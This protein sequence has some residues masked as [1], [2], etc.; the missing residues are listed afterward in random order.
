M[1]FKIK[2]VRVKIS[3]TFFAMV[4]LAVCLDNSGILL[5]SLISSLFHELVHIIFIFLCG[6]KISELSLSILGG[7]IQRQQNLKLSSIKE[8]I[9]SLSAPVFNIFTGA[10]ML[11]C[12]FK[13]VGYVNLVIGLLNVLPF[14]DFDGGRG[15]YYLLS[16]FLPQEK[17][18]IIQNITSVASVVLISSVTVTLFFQGGFSVSLVILGLYMI[19]SL[20]KNLSAE[21][22]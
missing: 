10:F 2:S 20:F 17:S 5:I 13:A 11:F 12:G 6:G 16:A 4:L 8:A 3:F 1:Q 19:F 7:R 21:N 22:L 15:L 18:R 14:F 9:I